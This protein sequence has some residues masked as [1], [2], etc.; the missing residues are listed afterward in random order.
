MAVPPFTLFFHPTDPLVHY[1]YAIPDEPPAGDIGPALDRL[2]EVARGRQRL[3]R[4]E[5]VE[6]FA[7]SLGA[8]LSANGFELEVAA[9]LM[10]ATAGSLAPVVRPAGLAVELLDHEA[11]AEKARTAVR[12]ARIAFGAPGADD[13][14][15]DDVAFQRR[16][17]GSGRLL[18][19]W[20]DGKAVGTAV[21][22]SPLGGVAEVAG[23]A[24][25]PEA[26]RLGIGGALT[27]DASRAAIEVGVATVF[28]SAG[29]ERAGRVYE[30]VGFSGIG[31][32]LAYR[33]AV[34]V[35]EPAGE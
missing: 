22:Q 34:A 18:L 15:D 31:S 23:V 5:F 11:P 17:I 10:V 25:L 29:T 12:L 8:T 26:R 27:E 33:D 20:L 7:P 1:N 2:R 16:S 13:V 32:V 9:W 30:R 4:F 6:A 3:P 24:T 21:L 19:A 28:L 14:S 35:I